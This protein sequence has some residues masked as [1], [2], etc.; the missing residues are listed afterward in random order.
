MVN[1]KVFCWDFD[2][3]LYHLTDEIWQ[4]MYHAQYTVIANHT[5]WSFDRARQEHEK[6][7]KIKFQSSQETTA[8]LSGLSIIETLKESE[9]YY[10]RSQFV[11]R[12]EKLIALFGSLRSFRHIMVVNGWRVQEEPVLDILGIPRTTFETWV[13]P[14]E[15]GVL[16][17][18]PKHLQAVLDYTHLPPETHLVIGDRETVDLVPAKSLGMKTCCVWQDKTSEVAD[19]TLPTVYD[20]LS[21]VV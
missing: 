7:Y 5:G 15:T 1:I 10:D 9:R 3:T 18:N 12:D 2:G 21:L 20:V 14:F 8:F 16:K 17:P 6:I 13:T 19:I 11:R 4:A